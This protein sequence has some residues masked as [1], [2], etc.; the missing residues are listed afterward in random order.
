MEAGVRRGD[1]SSVRAIFALRH[2]QYIYV[3]IQGEGL[4]WYLGTMKVI[5]RPGDGALMKGDL[6]H[7]YLVYQG[8][9]HVILH[10]LKQKRPLP[11]TISPHFPPLPLSI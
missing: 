8:I 6:I 7:Q 5:T 9:S 1:E 11:A 3:V 2:Q 10:H 4:A